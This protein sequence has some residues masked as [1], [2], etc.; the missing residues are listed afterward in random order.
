ADTHGASTQPIWSKVLSELERLRSLRDWDTAL[1]LVQ[2]MR[3]TPF[4]DLYLKRLDKWEKDIQLARNT[5]GR[6]WISRQADAPDPLW[7]PESPSAPP[8]LT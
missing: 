2:S 7:P 3:K 1:S 6:I 5:G 4:G 8:P